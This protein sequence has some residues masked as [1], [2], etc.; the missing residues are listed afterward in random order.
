MVQPDYFVTDLTSQIPYSLMIG[1]IGVSLEELD[2][3]AASG[4]P[5][6][7]GTYPDRVRVESF[8]VELDQEFL[9]EFAAAH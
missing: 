3:Y 6:L 8:E 4:E 2:Q 1:E 7:I 9:A 5:V